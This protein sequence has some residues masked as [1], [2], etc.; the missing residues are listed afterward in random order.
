MHLDKGSAA[1]AEEQLVLAKHALQ[2]LHLRGQRGEGSGETA[3]A[4]AAAACTHYQQP[5]LFCRH[6]AGM[7]GPDG[8]VTAAVVAP[9][10]VLVVISLL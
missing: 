10:G 8:G 4:A 6:S 3:A 9:D 1:C 2:L 7:I 5:R